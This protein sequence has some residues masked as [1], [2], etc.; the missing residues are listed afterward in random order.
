MTPYRIYL[1]EEDSAILFYVLSALA[2]VFFV[3][4]SI[5]DFADANGW[6]MLASAATQSKGGV[7]FF[8]F[9]TA[10]F[11]TIIYLLTAINL[12]LFCRRD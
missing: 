1:K 4:W 8:S 12:Y 2:L 9:F 5:A 10:F 3:I 6:I 7:A 11:S